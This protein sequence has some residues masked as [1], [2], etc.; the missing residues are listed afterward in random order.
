MFCRKLENCSYDNLARACLKN[1][2]PSIFGLAPLPVSLLAV[3]GD[4]L[5]MGDAKADGEKADCAPGVS[6]RIA[7]IAAVTG[8]AAVWPFD[9]IEWLSGSAVSKSCTHTHTHTHSVQCTGGAENKVSAFEI[10][11]KH[12]WIRASKTTTTTTMST[13]LSFGMEGSA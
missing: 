9:G 12:L 10:K 4:E 11:L 3:A 7:A 2:F 5:E 13:C 1:S 6:R 8:V